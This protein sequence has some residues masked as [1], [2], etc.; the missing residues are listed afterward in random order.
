MFYINFVF[1][2]Q[3]VTVTEALRKRNRAAGDAPNE[4]RTRGPKAVWA[5]KRQA[6]DDAAASGRDYLVNTATG[7]RARIPRAYSRSNSEKFY[8]RREVACA[9][10]RR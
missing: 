7:R 9:D 8:A 10:F 4:G 2:Y 5:E 1:D 6:S 3:G